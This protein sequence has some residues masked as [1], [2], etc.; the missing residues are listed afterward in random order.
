MESGHVPAAHTTG[1]YLMPGS[2]RWYSP[3]AAALL[4]HGVPGLS[5]E[6]RDALASLASGRCTHADAVRACST[7]RRWHLDAAFPGIPE[8]DAV[9]DLVI[10]LDAELPRTL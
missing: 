7:L 10:R 9:W 5:A 6:A 2:E 4:S 8:H 3:E 1:P